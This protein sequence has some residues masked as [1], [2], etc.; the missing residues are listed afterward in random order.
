MNPN[1]SGGVSQ[2]KG[3]T[4]GKSPVSSVRY[5]GAPGDVDMAHGQPRQYDATV[6]WTVP[7]WQSLDAPTNP[8]VPDQQVTRIPR[9]T[10]LQQS[11]ATAFWSP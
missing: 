5:N 9:A 8:Y 1:Q 2:G 3:L 4:F 10:V 7:Q 6:D 11:H